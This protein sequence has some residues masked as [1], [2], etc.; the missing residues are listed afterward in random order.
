MKAIVLGAGKGKRLQSEKFNLPK[1]LRNAKGHSLIEYVLNNIC[2]IPHSDT[3]IV[4]GYQKEAVIN[5][6][7]ADYCFAVQEEQLGTGHA[8]LCAKDCLNGYTGEILVLYGDMPLLRSETYQG[9]LAH[10]RETGADCTI[11]TAVDGNLR[12]FGRILR[13]PDGTLADMVEA[14]DCTPEQYAIEEVNAGVYVFQA[15]QLFENLSKLK[16]NNAQG[17]Y[18]LTDLPRIL[19]EQGKKISIYTVEN[20]LEIY[21]VNTMEDLAFCEA[22]L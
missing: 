7:P 15:D 14:K 4:V 10:H 18:Y 19:M 1:V 2:F 11:L 21:G 5:A 12:S 9:I 20:S 6:L 16:N 3:I 13:K 8:V 17:E 22:H